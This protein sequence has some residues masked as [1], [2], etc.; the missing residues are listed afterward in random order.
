MKDFGR[1]FNDQGPQEKVEEP[2]LPDGVYMK[3]GKAWATCR[4]CERGYE[5]FCE[6]HEHSQDMSYCGGSPRCIP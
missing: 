2:E 3:N 5:I 6:L 4:S 1:W